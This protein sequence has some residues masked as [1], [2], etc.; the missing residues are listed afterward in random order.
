MIYRTGVWDELGRT[1][2]PRA[3]VMAREMAQLLSDG[4]VEIRKHGRR[5]TVLRWYNECGLDPELHAGLLWGP[6]LE[7]FT[8]IVKE[9]VMEGL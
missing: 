5:W 8:D 3:Q 9:D 1:R 4:Q 7:K 2:P 6:A